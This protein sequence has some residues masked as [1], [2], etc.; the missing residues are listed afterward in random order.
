MSKYKNLSNLEKSFQIKTIPN[1]Y[2]IQLIKI[3]RNK[4]NSNHDDFIHYRVF[5]KIYN[6]TFQTII[7]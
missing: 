1:S 7:I 2:V 6:L 3:S 4:A 5:M